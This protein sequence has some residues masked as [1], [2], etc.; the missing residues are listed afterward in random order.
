MMD[1]EMPTVWHEREPRARKQHICCE[2]GRTISVG[3][4]YVLHEG[5]WGAEWLR[6]KTCMPCD[7]LRHDLCCYEEGFAYGEL[8]AFA[9]D[10][11]V[12][13]PPVWEPISEVGI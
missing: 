2:C 12:D 3:Q 4:I 7:A 1:A 8:S 11:G 6:F 13:Y 9:A 10:A 5:L